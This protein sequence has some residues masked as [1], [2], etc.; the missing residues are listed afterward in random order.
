MYKLH[1]YYILLL[2]TSLKADASV[3]DPVF[4]VVVGGRRNRGKGRGKEPKDRMKG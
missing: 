3:Q 4:Q 1:T 2:R